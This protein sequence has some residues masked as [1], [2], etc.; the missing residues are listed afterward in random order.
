MLLP[1]KKLLYCVYFYIPLKQLKHFAEQTLLCKHMELILRSP[2]LQLKHWC[3]SGLECSVKR[4]VFVLK[5]HKPTSRVVIFHTAGI[6][7]RDRAIGSR[8]FNPISSEHVFASRHGQ[9]SL[10]MLLLL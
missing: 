3:G 9:V 6:V 1:N 8:V 10:L 4:I 2:H 5:K 7:T